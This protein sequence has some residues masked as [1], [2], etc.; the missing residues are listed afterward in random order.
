MASFTFREIL[1]TLNFC[2]VGFL[3]CTIFL[4]NSGIPK[5]DIPQEINVEI[6]FPRLQN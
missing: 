5:S 3:F 1:N 6:N 4:R 2:D